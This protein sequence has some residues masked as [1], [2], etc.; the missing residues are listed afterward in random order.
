MQVKP[1]R[2][3]EEIVAIVKSTANQSNC[4]HDGSCMR[5]VLP[6]MFVTPTVSGYNYSQH[7]FFLLLLIMLNTSIIEGPYDQ[8]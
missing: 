5:K 7:F 2:T 4:C 6:N 8:I 1:Q 3:S